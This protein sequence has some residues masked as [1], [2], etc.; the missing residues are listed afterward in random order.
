MVVRERKKKKKDLLAY[1]IN[2]LWFAFH[3]GLI[4]IKKKKKENSCVLKGM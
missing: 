4:S 2:I 3:L 1:P